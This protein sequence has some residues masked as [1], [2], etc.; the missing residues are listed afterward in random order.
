MRFS[1]TLGPSGSLYT[2][3]KIQPGSVDS[4]SLTLHLTS[5]DGLHS[6][7]L[8]LLPPVPL[9]PNPSE[10]HYEHEV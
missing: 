2:L 10:L 4:C 1:T 3:Q 5:P 6:L 7:L 9:K 8:T